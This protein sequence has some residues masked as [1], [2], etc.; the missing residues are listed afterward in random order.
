MGAC[1]VRWLGYK[2]AEGIVVMVRDIEFVLEG[3]DK[4][5][6]VRRKP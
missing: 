1:P 4:E 6:F 3:I 2:A 5:A